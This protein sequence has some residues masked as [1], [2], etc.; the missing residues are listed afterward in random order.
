M[1]QLLFGVISALMLALLVLL[2]KVCLLRKAAREMAEAFRDKLTTDT[3]T[4]ISLSCRDPSM[5]K[6]A[7][8]INAELRLLRSERHRYQQG[9]QELKNAVT[10]ISHDLRTP[11]TAI[12]GYLELLEKEPQTEAAQRY[13]TIVDERAQAMK[14]LTEELFRYSMILAAADAPAR[15]SVC[16]NGVLEEAVAAQYTQ[17]CSRSITPEI[18]LPEAPVMRRLNRDA[19]S[20]IFGN[21]IANAARY[22][23]GDLCIRL[24]EDGTAA[25]SNTA[26]ALDEVQVGRLFDRFYTVESA[27]RSTGLGLAIARNLTEQMGGEIRASYAGGVLTITIV[28]RT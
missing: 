22:S 4:L 28:F 26:S 21:L 18:H 16:L 14:R 24:C 6:L 9:D 11:L 2:A 17:L 25:F 13:L 27:H 7:S 12:C 10:N 19:L 3:N 1:E 15:E 5:R 20:R 23:D 8:E